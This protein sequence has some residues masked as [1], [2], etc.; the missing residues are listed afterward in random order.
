MSNIDSA[1]GSAGASTIQVSELLAVLYNPTSEGAVDGA[2]AD[3]K[4]AAEKAEQ[5]R[6]E[7]DEMY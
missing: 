5:Q 3:A 6:I 2:E 4:R 1:T 7:Q